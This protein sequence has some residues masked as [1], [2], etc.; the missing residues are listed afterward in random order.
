MIIALTGGI[1]SGK[2]E[3][4]RQFAA[5]GVPIVDTDV[6]AHALVAVGQPLLAEIQQLFGA[7]FINDDGTLNRAKLREH[8]FHNP[9]ERL[10]LE[11]L[12]H[13]AIHAEAMK[14][15]AENA[16]QRAPAYQILVVPLL[17]ENNRYQGIADKTLVIDTDESLQIARAMARSNMSATNVQAMM[18]AQVARNVRLSLADEIIVNNGT[19]LELTEKVALFHKKLIKT[20]IVSK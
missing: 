4:S 12:M 14:Q 15:L 5:L 17:F 16:R 8:V 1:G 13:P 11:A 20:C 9:A 19:L 10:K 7:S 2:S 18:A 6:I 3:V